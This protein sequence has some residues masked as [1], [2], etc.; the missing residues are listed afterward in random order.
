ML[1]RYALHIPTEL[2]KE[3]IEA[4]P[5]SMATTEA[6]NLKF[7][8]DFPKLLADLKGC[9]E[10]YVEGSERFDIH[11]AKSWATATQ[12]EHP[13]DG[14]VHNHG[15]AHLSF[16]IYVQQPMGSGDITFD[17]NNV[18]RSFPTSENMLIIFPAWM[19]HYV[20]A[21]KSIL[22]RYSIAGDIILTLKDAYESCEFLTPV[23]DWL[24]LS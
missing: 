7:L 23:E 19:P 9:V 16:V 10:D 2:R 11:L 14:R 8:N 20:P 4:M 12:P 24:C 3:I 22:P 17:I 6:T 5:P 13:H 15:Y 18:R 21:N 1:E